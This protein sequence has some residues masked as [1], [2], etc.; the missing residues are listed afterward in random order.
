[1]HAPRNTQDEG[2][3]PFRAHS[4]F[5]N[6]SLVLSSLTALAFLVAFFLHDSDQEH[7]HAHPH[8]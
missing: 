1:M 5:S 4:P 3:S 8:R 6:S 2:A 7:S